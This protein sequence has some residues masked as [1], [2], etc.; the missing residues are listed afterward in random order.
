M[1]RNH[2]YDYSNG[3]ELVVK[4]MVMVMTMVMI[5]VMVMAVTN[6]N[7]SIEM[8]KGN[9]KKPRLKTEISRYIMIEN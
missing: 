8:F 5:M 3:Y 2:G 4:V 7:F 1:C 6:W 9:Y